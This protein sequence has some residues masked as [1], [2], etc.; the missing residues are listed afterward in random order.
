MALGERIKTARLEKGL[1]QRQLSGDTITRNMLSLIENGSAKPSMDTLRILA[2]RL[3]KPIGYFLEEDV[4]ITPNQRI[5]L[6]ARSAPPEEALALLK[7]Y[8]KPDALFD[9]EYYLLTALSC[10]ALSEQA[11]GEN[12]TRLA[13]NYLQQAAEA[14]A[15]TVYYTP[16]QETRRLLLCHKA[17]IASAPELA[18]QLPDN[19]AELMLRAQAALET[20]DAPRSA[21]L[22]DSCVHRDAQWH[23]LRGEACLQQQ[24]YAQA[25]PH[26]LEAEKALAAAVYPQ[27]ELCFRELEDYKQ[28]YQYACKQKQP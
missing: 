14:G 10:M 13:E 26:F 7:D 15:A 20:E 23:L 24:L 4:Q 8:K 3:E 12:R 17:G 27:L 21:A 18:E 19:T 5:I 9:P 1:S 25:I 22:L 6:K 2:A 28:A 16:E 11:I